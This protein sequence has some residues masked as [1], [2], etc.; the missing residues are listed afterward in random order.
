M[1]SS[2]FIGD[3]MLFLLII[4][5]VIQWMVDR[6]FQQF[7]VTTKKKKKKNRKTPTL[8][9]H[10]LLASSAVSSDSDLYYFI[11]VYLLGIVL[12]FGGH[13]NKNIIDRVDFKQ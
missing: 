8:S 5:P 7:E 4:P 1:P 3:H 12:V 9:D 2:S 10:H 11:Q 13:C 6:N